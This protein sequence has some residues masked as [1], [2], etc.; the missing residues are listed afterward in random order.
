VARVHLRVG[1][2]VRA[3]KHLSSTADPG[4]TPVTP[5]MLLVPGLPVQALRGSGLWDASRVVAANADG[6][7]R[8]HALGATAS[9]DED[10]PRALIRVG[11]VIIPE[12]QLYS[13]A[14]PGGARVTPAT[15]LAPGQL[16]QVQWGAGWYQGRVV[17][18]NA[19][20]AVRIHYTGWDFT[21]DETVPRE[22]IRVG[23]VIAP[24]P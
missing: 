23:G 22:R 6:T 8:V 10:V 2:T 1:G 21:H 5:A 11:G 14:D 7:V 18:L 9:D 3:G 16:V 4:G 20:G 24:P 15:T 12:V 13:P 17:A 19:G